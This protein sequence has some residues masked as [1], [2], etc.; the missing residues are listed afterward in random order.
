MHKIHDTC[1]R[2]VTFYARHMFS[3]IHDVYTIYIYIYIFMYVCV[4]KVRVKVPVCAVYVHTITGR[5][6]TNF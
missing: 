3:N 4:A 2:K 1:N 5:L 6:M